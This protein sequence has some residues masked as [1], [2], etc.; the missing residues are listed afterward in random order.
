MIKIII[1]LFLI[2]LPLIGQAQQTIDYTIMHDGLEREYIL[3]IPESYS[4][5][6]ASPLLCNFH[7]LGS[8]AQ[9]Q[10]A[11]GDFRP[12]ADRDG[13]LVTHPQGTEI[14][15]GDRGWNIGPSDA[16][17]VGFIAAMIASIADEYN[18][19]RERVYA[20][21]MSIGGFFS[22]HLANLLSDDIAA[23]ASVSGSM[24]QYMVDVA[25]PVHPTPVIQIHGT[26]DP[27][28]PYDGNP[29]FLSV[30][31]VLQY[32]VDFNSCNTTPIITQVPD[33]NPDN[34]ITVEHHVYDGGDNNVKV[35]H[36]KVFGGTHA[37]PRITEQGG[38]D[39]DASE[40]IWKFLSKYDIN[41][42]IDD[43]TSVEIIS[44]NQIP[45]NDIL[46][47]NYPNP[48]NSQTTIWFTLDKP[49]HVTL[50]IY[51]ATGDI[52]HTLV[53]EPKSAGEYS[54]VWNGTDSYG[55]EM[56]TGIYFYR[57][58]AIDVH[59]TKSMILLKY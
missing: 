59:E 22:H 38:N 19:D 50:S 32:W 30:A 51:N 36:F 8:N 23:I 5:D 14:E 58:D 4:G 45:T 21:G 33:I 44:E 34:P 43:E 42:L 6:E 31:E 41:G 11:F 9:Q 48:F 54:S 37:W 28:V 47:Q 52:I 2:G 13:F 55:K 46:F 57:I 15:F 20:T 40:E 53:D 39:I 10:M 7:A 35:E 3:Y 12:I 29:G 18:I 17:D 49:G 56:N 1:I 27:L 26:K 24:T 25:E 16:D